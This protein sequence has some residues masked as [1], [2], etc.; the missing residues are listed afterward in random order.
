MWGLTEVLRI[1]GAVLALLVGSVI[2]R[3]HPRDRS[4]RASAFLLA[5]VIAHLVLPLLLRERAATGA[6]HVAL[7][8][9]SSVPFAFWLIAQIHF[10]D[11]FVAAPKHLWLLAGS[12]G[13]S[14]LCWLFSPESEGFWMVVPKLIGIA[15]IVHALIRIHVGTRSDLVLP[16]LRLRY[17]VLAVAGTYILLELIG[18]A[19]IRGAA[20]ER[21]ADRVHSAAVAALLFGIAF[22]AL[23]A[24]RQI[25]KPAKVGF[26]TPA[27]D[28]QL[29]DRLRRL[30][31]IDEVYRVEG[32]TV[33]G[34]AERLG[35]EEHKLREMINTHLGFKNFNAFLHHY[36]IGEAQRALR[37]PTRTE[38]G[39]AQIAFEV[40]YRSL[41]TFNKAFK[42]LTGR[43]PTQLRE[44]R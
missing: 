32:L 3:D 27:P 9:A 10:D 26:D 43:T 12:A 41:A 24:N 4:A 23:R 36:R 29:L 5:G 8:L 25:L 21:V 34:L 37:D 44:S 39:V 17:A 16:R 28:T 14:Y 40:G 42:E 20:A 31:E 19:V 2:L 15:L 1:V 13:V 11:D 7:L 38:T 18:E 30:L 33:R 6:I 22:F 35:T